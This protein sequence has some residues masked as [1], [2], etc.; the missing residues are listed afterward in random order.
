MS[1][2]LNPD[3][4]VRNNILFVFDGENSF[5]CG[6]ADPELTFPMLLGLTSEPLV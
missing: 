4:S 6:T 3:G 2:S 5:S 1:Q